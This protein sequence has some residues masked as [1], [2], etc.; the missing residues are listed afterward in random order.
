MGF[1]EK[2]FSDVFSKIAY[3]VWEYD[4]LISNDEKI[5]EA[6]QVKKWLLTCLLNALLFGT[7]T[8]SADELMDITRKAYQT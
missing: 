8:V 5:R 4:I 3:F 1:F 7:T 2:Y 6:S